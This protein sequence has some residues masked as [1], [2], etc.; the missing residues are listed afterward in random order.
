MIGYCFFYSPKTDTQL[1]TILMSRR[2]GDLLPTA[3]SL[4]AVLNLSREPGGEGLLGGM[5]QR[6]DLWQPAILL[7]RQEEKAGSCSAKCGHEETD[8]KEQKLYCFNWLL[9]GSDSYFFLEDARF[10]ALPGGS[11]HIYRWPLQFSYPFP[12]SQCCQIFHVLSLSTFSV[13]MPHPPFFFSN[14]FSFKYFQVRC[15]TLCDMQH[16]SPFPFAR[17][18]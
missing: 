5:F 14:K 9:L 18:Q 15:C 1:I 17:L 13:L 10:Y 11:Q 3:R 7:Q 8:W 4:G 2:E 12:S 16:C 6:G